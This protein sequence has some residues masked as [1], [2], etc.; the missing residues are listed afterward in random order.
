M[1][2]LQE[3]LDLVDGRRQSDGVEKSAADKY[4]VA[5]QFRR[6]QPQR[7]HLI[8]QEAIDPVVESNRIPDELFSRWNECHLHRRLLG[9]ITHQHDELARL[10]ERHFAIGRHRP[11]AHGRRFV[12]S[13]PRQIARRPVR[14]KA[15]DLDAEMIIRACQNHTARRH[16]QLRKRRHI[17]RVFGATG[18]D[19]IAQHPI[20]ERIDRKTRTALMGDR[21]AGLA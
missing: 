12:D 2:I 20:F 19:P 6:S 14:K 17:R 15:F 8:E 13:Q 9:Q 3:R 11:D 16:R 5:R 18:G 21:S 10:I 7:F 1:A 4:A